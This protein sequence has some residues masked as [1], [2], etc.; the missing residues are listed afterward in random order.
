MLIHEKKPFVRGSL[1]LISFLAVFVILLT[2]VMPDP[3]KP[4][5]HLT[6]LQFA[7]DVFNKLS[8]GSSYFIP[9]VES[10]VKT[11]DGKFVDFTVPVK[12]AAYAPLAAMLATRAGA[13]ASVEDGKLSVSGDL[14]MILAAATAD[15]DLMY[16]NDAAGVLARYEADAEVI[17]SSIDALKA[18]SGGVSDPSVNADQERALAV[19]GSW[20]YALQPAIKDLQKQGLFAEA[21][22][23]DT[24]VRRALE[25]GHNFFSIQE[26]KVSD[27][28][29][30]MAAML[31]FYVLYTLWYGFSIFE[32]F[33]G[34]GLAMTKS[35]VKKEG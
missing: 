34:I 15:A 8:K 1:M 32:L 12:K 18:R 4:G 16:K 21:K 27:H 13:D 14:G 19:T 3:E 9:A 2:P 26:A 5:G 11:V 25:P 24:V 22:V 7:D 29:F 28:V 23:V 6:G 33:E 20:W 35:K 10:A 30:L 17:A 31:V